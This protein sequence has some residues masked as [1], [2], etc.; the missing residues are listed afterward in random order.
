MTDF[1]ITK[2]TAEVFYIR[3]TGGF[4]WGIFF[5]DETTGTLSCV[6]DYGDYAY[7]WGNNHGRKSFKDF[8]AREGR[9]RHYFLKKLAGQSCIEYKHDETVQNWKKSLIEE[10]K[11]E[12]CSKDDARHVW[13]LIDGL[14]DNGA[15]AVNEMLSDRT[16][17][18]V[19]GPEVICDTVRDYT[20]SATCFIDKLWPMFIEAL[21]G[22]AGEVAS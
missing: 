15:L 3:P 4:G 10:R 22:D 12:Y 16:A 18:S 8:L 11:R 13:D 21:R 17:N 9:D 20:A 19:L 1:S 14:E 7:R 6:S 2:G 5:L